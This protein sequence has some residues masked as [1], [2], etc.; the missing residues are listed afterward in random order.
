MRIGEKFPT[1]EP[2]IFL[3]SYKSSQIKRL[4]S[5]RDPDGAVVQAPARRADL[6]LVLGGLVEIEQVLVN[7][8]LNARDALETQPQR[9]VEIRARQHG[10]NVV[11]TITDTGTGIPPELLSRIF[12]PFFTTKPSGKGTGLGLAISR[13]TMV[14]IGGSIEARNTGTG[15]EFT[16]VFP[17]MEVPD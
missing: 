14:A 2:F 17:T 12:D 6:P 7:L 8:L 1:T 4:A 16:L 9:R 5:T 13:K 11:L 3:I 15:T 10:Q